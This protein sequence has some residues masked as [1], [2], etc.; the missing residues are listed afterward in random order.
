MPTATAVRGSR[1]I[2]GSF[3]NLFPKYLA[4]WNHGEWVVFDG[5]CKVH[6]QSGLTY[7][8]SFLVQYYGPVLSSHYGSVSLSL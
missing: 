1:E 8:C 3:K 2:L 5:L 6:A 7:K 4:R